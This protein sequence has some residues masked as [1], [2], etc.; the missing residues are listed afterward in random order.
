MSNQKINKQPTFVRF[1]WAS[2]NLI[3]IKSKDQGKI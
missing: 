1:N 2:A 3:L